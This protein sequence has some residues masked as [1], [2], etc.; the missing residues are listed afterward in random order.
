MVF[1]LRLDQ[2]LESKN[3]DNN[4]CVALLCLSDLGR[5]GF[6]TSFSVRARV[7]AGNEAARG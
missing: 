4:A 7:F 1:T 5:L 2:L 3:F 6:T